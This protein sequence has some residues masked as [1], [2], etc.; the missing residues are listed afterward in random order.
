MIREEVAHSDGT[1]LSCL[2]SFFQVTIG[3]VAVAVRLVEEHQVDVVGLQFAQTLIDALHSLSV[4]IVGR[5]DLGNEENLITIH[6]AFLPC[7]AHG[8][9]VEI[10]LR[11]I[12]HPIAHAE[13]IQHTTL[14]LIRFHL[15]NTV[16]KLWHFHAIT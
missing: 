14:T 16:S 10:S 4:A 9:L 6:A 8:F 1:N 2:V 7:V 3:T 13:S 5:P 11:S 15:I 12:Y